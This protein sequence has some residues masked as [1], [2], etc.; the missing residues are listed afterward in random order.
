MMFAPINSN[1]HTKSV[2]FTHMAM[3]AYVDYLLQSVVL[4]VL[5]RL[6]RTSPKADLTALFGSAKLADMFM[7]IR[8]CS[9]ME[10]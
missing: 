2:F 1:M 10:V 4:E 3:C 5:F 7:E 8:T 6:H 9:F